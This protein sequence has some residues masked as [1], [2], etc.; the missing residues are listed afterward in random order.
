MKKTLN[1]FGW[2]A[3]LVLL[4]LSTSIPARAFPGPRCMD[5]DGTSCPRVLQTTT[6]WYLN[7]T[8]GNCQCYYPYV[9]QQGPYVWHCTNPL[10]LFTLQAAPTCIAEG[11]PQQV[12]GNLFV[13][14]DRP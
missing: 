10:A 4:A 7:G 6:C 9:G 2:T 13:A 14:A 11:R 12:E 8:T 3:I 1:R 5:I